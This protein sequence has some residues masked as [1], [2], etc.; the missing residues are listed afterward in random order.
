MKTIYLA[1]GVPQVLVAQ[2]TK[3]KAKFGK[4]GGHCSWCGGKMKDIDPTNN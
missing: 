1:P 2:C 3:C 4:N